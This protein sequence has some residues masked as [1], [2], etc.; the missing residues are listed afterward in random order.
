MIYAFVIYGNKELT[1]TRGER[2]HSGCYTA[3]YKWGLQIKSL[4]YEFAWRFQI[5]V[6]LKS[7]KKSVS[8]ECK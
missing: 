1:T 5:G 2:N 6:S 3:N 7:L 8:T 4:H